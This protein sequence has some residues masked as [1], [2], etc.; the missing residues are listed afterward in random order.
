LFSNSYQPF[1]QDNGTP[2]GSN[3]EKFT[4]KPWDAPI[5]LYYFYQRWYDPS[6]GRFVSWDP[7]PGRLSNPQSFNAFIYV[8]NNPIVLTDPSGMDG[9]SLWDTQSWLGCLNNTGQ[10]LNT[11]VIQPAIAYFD[12]H[13]VKPILDNRVVK[14][15]IIPVVK[16]V[17]VPYVTKKYNDLVTTTNTLAN[18]G[19]D[20]WNRYTS[21]YQAANNGIKSFVSTVAKMHVTDNH[22]F[23]WGLVNCGGLI[24]IGAMVAFGAP[25]VLPAIPLAYTI[26]AVGGTAIG[27]AYMFSSPALAALYS[28]SVDLANGVVG[29]VTACVDTASAVSFD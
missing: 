15:I 24:A 7:K 4:G 3:T 8:V 18:V 13:V 1:G 12:T 2:T 14:D 10:A 23:G 26:Y 20:A 27:M 11:N 22:K 6:I 29:M 5:G 9:C 17:V 16:D 19:D 28:A 21:T 25:A